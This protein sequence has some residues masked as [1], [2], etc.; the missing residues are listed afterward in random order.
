MYQLIISR[1]SCEITSTHWGSLTLKT[2]AENLTS[3]PARACHDVMLWLIVTPSKFIFHN[4]NRKTGVPSIFFYLCFASFKSL[5]CL[6]IRDTPPQGHHW[7]TEIKVED[8]IT[9]LA[10]LGFFRNWVFFIIL[11]IDSPYNHVILDRKWKGKKRRLVWGY[12]RGTF[13]WPTPEVQC[14]NPWSIAHCVLY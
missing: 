8:T 5:H 7:K 2:V 13:M 4:L 3:T 6:T 12:C 10:Q 11:S 1:Q 9:A 14:G